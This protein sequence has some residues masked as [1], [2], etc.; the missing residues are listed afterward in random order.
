MLL[1]RHGRQPSST[2]SPVMC[3]QKLD[4]NMAANGSAAQQANQDW[5]ELEPALMRLSSMAGASGMLSI[6]FC[7]SPA[8]S[9]A[10]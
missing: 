8:L 1:F 9:K 10:L 6:S 5:S 2:M 7:A 4:T 3:T